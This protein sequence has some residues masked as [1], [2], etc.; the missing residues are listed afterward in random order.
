MPE[1]MPHDEP[2][3]HADTSI[4]RNGANQAK[5][6]GAMVALCAS[7]IPI[8]Y[9]AYYIY[10]FSSALPVKDQWDEA[11]FIVSVKE[12]H[13]NLSQLFHFR[14]EHCI[15]V[16]RLLFAGLALLFNWDNRAECWLTF[17]FT[18]VTFGL[19]CRLVL[20]DR[21]RGEIV[22]LVALVV[23]A[24]FLFSTTQW[25]NWLWGFQLAWPI[26]VLV[27]TVAISSL[28]R[29]RESIITGIVITAATITAVLSMGTGFIVPLILLVVLGGRYLRSRDRRMLPCVA[30]CAC[31]AALSLGFFFTN[32]SPGAGATHFGI[33]SLQGIAVLLANP[34]LDYTRSVPGS[35]LGFLLFAF[36]VSIVLIVL[37]IWF[38]VRGFRANAFESPLFSIGFALA[39]W[40]LLSVMAITLAR[41]HL[42]FEGLAQ[43][44][45]ISYAVLLPVGVSFMAVALL[46]RR[47]MPARGVTLC[48]TWIFLSIGLAV[49]PL[50]GEP[51]RLQWGRDMHEVYITLTEFVKVAPVFPIESELQRICPQANRLAV[52]HAVARS[53]LIR[54]M[55]PPGKDLPA[56]MV[57][58]HEPVGNIDAIV[59]TESGSELNGWCAFL[60]ARGI[61]DAVFLGTPN[62]DGSVELLAPIVERKGHRPDVAAKGGPLES[63]WHLRLPPEYAGKTVTLFAYDWSSNKFY[64]SQGEWQL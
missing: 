43:S 16:P 58:M 63:G 56:P 33:N 59:R 35:L 10:A 21:E 22:G 54:G 53:R 45:Y 41:S 38:S 13:L 62:P 64:R 23:A 47:D 14:G 17:V 48:R 36:V 44:R 61:P 51:S 9:L 4:A 30:L 37:F 25:Q 24:I 60:D 26:P 40:A 49:M 28:Y 7:A 50:R 20:K 12:G 18:A 34:F 46:R 15:V 2:P 5:R 57:Q 42:G 52:I 55:V 8:L 29:W 39:A 1:N 32:Q 6:P 11:P 27:L 31:L 3:I 19:L